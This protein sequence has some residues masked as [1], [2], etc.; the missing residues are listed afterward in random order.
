MLTSIHLLDAEHI[1]IATVEKADIVLSW[2]FKHIVNIQK[3]KGF[4]S[5][6]LKEGYQLLEIRTPREVLLNEEKI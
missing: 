5:I 4:N 1:A 6:N 2:N 3:I